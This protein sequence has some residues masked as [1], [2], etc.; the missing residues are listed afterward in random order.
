MYG[1]TS[2]LRHYIWILHLKSH[3]PKIPKRLII[4]RIWSFIYLSTSMILSNIIREKDLATEI[5]WK[6]VH[7]VV[8]TDSGGA[9][10]IPTPPTQFKILETGVSSSQGNTFKITQLNTNALFPPHWYP[11]LG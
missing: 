11:F 7:Y 4:R 5:R 9:R 2:D 1:R 10:L 3:I 8:S 6:G